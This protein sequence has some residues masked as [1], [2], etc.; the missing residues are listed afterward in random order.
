[1]LL[2]AIL[3]VVGFTAL[4]QLGVNIAPLLAGAS[5]IGVALGFGS[6]K[7]VQDVINGM[8][9]LLENAM[10]VGDWVTVSGLSGSVEAL[11]VRT[12]RLRAGAPVRVMITRDLILEPYQP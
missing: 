7:L 12:I 3:I 6:Q 4:S 5:I 1:M 11:S 9:L 8:F 2:T 10:Q